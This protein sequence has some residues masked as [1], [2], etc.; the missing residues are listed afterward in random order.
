MRIQ[1]VTAFLIG[2][3]SLPLSHASAT[4]A[5][6][7]SS[8]PAI[9]AK[10]GEPTSQ[11]ELRVQLRSH[12]DRSKPLLDPRFQADSIRDNKTS[13]TLDDYGSLVEWEARSKLLC[14]Q[15]RLA[16]GLFPELKRFERKANVFG[17]LHREGYTVEKVYVET[18]PGFYVTGNLYR[19]TNGNPPYPAL[20]SPHGHWPQGRLEDSERGSVPGRCIQ[21]ARMGFVV[22][23]YDM[24]GYIDSRPQIEHNFGKKREALWGLSAM[25]LQLRNGLTVV[26]FL[27]NLEDVD[28]ERIGCTGASGGGTQTFL[29][30]AVDP[31]IKACA[32]VNMISAHFQGGCLCENGPML[33]RNTFNVE[34]G[35]LAA[36]RPMILV[37]CTG[38]WTSNTLEVEH[39]AIQSIYRLYGAEHNLGAIRVE[40]EHNYNRQS[41]EAVYSFFAHVFQGALEDTLIQETP[42][43]VEKEEDLRVF[44]DKNLPEG[45]VTS[46]EMTE[47]YIQS[48]L[49]TL[50]LLFPTDPS[51]LISF[52]EQIRES[53][54][55]VVLGPHN[56]KEG[57]VE[58][59]RTWSD[60]NMQVHGCIL[61][62]SDQRV[63]IPC[64][65]IPPKEGSGSRGG[66]LLVHDRGKASF[67]EKNET[68][69]G[70][71]PMQLASQGFHVL[72]M[73]VFDQGEAT[74]P[75]TLKQKRDLVDFFDTYNLTETSE[76]VKDCMTGL[77]FL[78]NR[79]P[80]QSVH[81]VGLGQAGIWAILTRALAPMEGKTVADCSSWPQTDQDFLDTCYIPCLRRLGGLRSA[82]A[83][84]APGDVLLA[85]CHDQE[86]DWIQSLYAALHASEK[87]RL[88]PKSPTWKRLVTWLARP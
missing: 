19:P 67:L 77:A 38:D 83:L 79:C 52:Q 63:A 74:L 30:T 58:N 41:R 3:F 47:G 11:K 34:I 1:S 5:K 76:R 33:R 81:L 28:R 51:S 39:P 42:F 80:G 36:P 22:F 35:A 27:E 84:Q 53:F 72:L 14:Q 9:L 17:K 66:V 71:L 29:L 4:I 57:P 62:D 56:P 21:L 31:R 7:T 26:D 50:A 25:G 24:I 49:E 20:A 68:R 82:L 12:E 64:L 86:M 40:A 75:N 61:R 2:F 32:P 44:M 85:N 6:G 48:C 54:R 8:N 46:E 15:I 60:R 10:D 65:H 13:H 78:R 16:A 87:L 43:H 45:H 18:L 55:L 23:S 73:D 37:S 70:R 69:L 88:E 59:I